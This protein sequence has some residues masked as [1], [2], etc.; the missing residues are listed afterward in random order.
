MASPS[1]ERVNEEQLCPEELEQ[2]RQIHGFVEYLGHAVI[3][4][5]L[6]LVGRNGDGCVQPAVRVDQ[7]DSQGIFTR[8]D[9]PLR[10]V[11]HFASGRLRPAAT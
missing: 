1:S 9:A 7:P 8:P 10:D 2:Q 3:V 5:Q 4:A 6:R 11:E